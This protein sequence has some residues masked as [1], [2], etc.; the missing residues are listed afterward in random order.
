MNLIYKKEDCSGC[1]ACES[2]CPTKAITMER[3]NMGFN[4]PIIDD[5]LCVECGL[6]K[7]VCPLQNEI[8]V[9]KHLSEPI[10]YAA[11][12]KEDDVRMVSSSGG[13]YTAISNY[14]INE[15]KGICYGATFNKDFSVVHESACNL[16]ERDKFRG[17][18]YVQSELNDTFKKIKEDLKKNKAVLFTGVPCQTAGLI[19]YLKMAK[20]D[21]SHLILND[22][23]CHG[24]QSPMIWEDYVRFIENKNQSKLKSY[25]FR[26]KDM[27]WRGYNVRAVFKDGSVKTNTKDILKY[28]KLF[29]S[30]LALRPSCYYCKFS[31]MNRP[32]DLMIGDFWGIEN[33]FPNFEDEKGVSLVLVN[34]EKGKEVFDSIK[35]N[36][37]YKI[38]SKDK[39][40]QHN[41][42][43]PTEEPKKSVYFWREYNSGELESIIDKYTSVGITLKLKRY[44][45]NILKNK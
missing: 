26:A 29:K 17:S 30:N 9:D 15:K 40:M 4:Y 18:K 11:K 38:S 33:T 12:Y 2:I 14:V 42:Q 28:I 22:I 44:I 20:V 10:I 43:K 19:K 31:N 34:T 5:D 3:D 1:T 32:S 24:V 25:T 41:L 7:N 16:S 6:C 39:C 35:E 36:L 23:I 21:T 45:K 37:I 27:G 8:E 13:I